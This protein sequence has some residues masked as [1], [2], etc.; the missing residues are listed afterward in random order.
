MD[1][2]GGRK[3][4][5]INS[6]THI[7]NWM[8]KTDL[9]D[10]WRM[11]HPDDNIYTW[12][13]NRPSNIFCRLDFFFLLSFGLVESI[14]KSQVNCGYKSDH[15]VI[16]IAF[17]PHENKR[18]TGFWKLNRDLLKDLDCIKTVKETIKTTAEIN[19]EA[20][21]NLSRDTIKMGVRGDL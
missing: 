19:H 6:Q 17:I 1:Q 10:I 9:E 14:A 15:S 12:H 11:Q 4:T 3:T 13:R 18:E 20:C 5:N 7:K 21:P 8:Q 16:S 2:H